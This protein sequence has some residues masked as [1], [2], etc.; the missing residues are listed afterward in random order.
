MIVIRRR[1]CRPVRRFRFHTA[2]SAS[3]LRCRVTASGRAH[4]FCLQLRYIVFSISTVFGTADRRD[5]GPRHFDRPQ[6]STKYYYEFCY[7]VVGVVAAT[8][9]ILLSVFS[10]LCYR[11]FSSCK[12]QQISNYAFR[13]RRYIRQSRRLSVSI[14]RT[15]NVRQIPQVRWSYLKTAVIVIGVGRVAGE[16]AI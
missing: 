10:C 1:R 14:A 5:R 3:R 6:A 8:S 2:A 15:T 11:I 13:S 7:Y 4:P 9:S 12:Q 16:N